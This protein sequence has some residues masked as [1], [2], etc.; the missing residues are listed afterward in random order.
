MSLM[1]YRA[2]TVVN[3]HFGRNNK[4]AFDEESVVIS[5]AIWGK[6][7]GDKQTRFIV[8]INNIGI[9]HEKAIGRSSLYLVVVNLLGRRV[10]SGIMIECQTGI[11]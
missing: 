9:A 7:I 2:P 11:S 5:I 3:N 8:K 1:Y 4:G 10:I 6:C